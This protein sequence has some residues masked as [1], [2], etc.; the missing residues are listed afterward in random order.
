MKTWHVNNT[1]IAD[2][3]Y[4]DTNIDKFIMLSWISIYCIPWLRHDNVVHNEPTLLQPVV[5]WHVY[6]TKHNTHHVVRVVRYTLYVRG[7][8]IEWRHKMWRRY[9]IVSPGGGH[10]V[11]E[12][13]IHVRTT[14]ILYGSI[15]FTFFSTCYHYII[16][17][18]WLIQKGLALL[19]IPIWYE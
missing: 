17:Y 3:H 4:G 14:T 13:R 10:C 9:E 19:I 15:T 12:L 6:D 8:R 1:I 11:K 2:E 16:L 18:F 5:G 7:A